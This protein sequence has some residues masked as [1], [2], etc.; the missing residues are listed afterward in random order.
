ME[1]PAEKPFDRKGFDGGVYELIIKKEPV[2]GDGEWKILRLDLGKIP[3]SATFRFRQDGDEMRVF[4]G[5]TKSLK[6][7]FNERKIPVE[8][9]EWLP[10][11]ADGKTVLAVCGVEISDG[12]K[13]DAETREEAYIYLRKKK[14][15]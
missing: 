14:R 12:V 4:G 5:S 9:R 8:A 6:K 1:K 7:L 11:I 10:L 3:Q 13:V 2:E 15:R